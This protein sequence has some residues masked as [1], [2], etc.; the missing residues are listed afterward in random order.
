MNSTGLSRKKLLKHV[1]FFS[2]SF[3][4][5]NYVDVQQVYKK[6]KSALTFLSN[7]E[8][9]DMA[10][11]VLGPNST[12]LWIISPPDLER[13]KE[14]LEKNIT[15]KV[16]YKY[17]IS[18]VTNTE[19]IAETVTAE[20]SFDLKADSPAR[21]EILKMLNKTSS[22]G[23]RSQ[24]PFLFPKFLKVI[25]LFHSQVNRTPELTE[26]FHFY[27]LGEKFGRFKA[28]TATFSGFN[29]Q[30]RISRSLLSKFNTHLP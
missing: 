30:H 8:A 4:E 9:A 22:T 25:L 1:H 17:A 3:N 19:K 18:R 10:A 15:L 23:K 12:S 5:K 28:S 16:Q 29:Y 7:Y 20:R 14:D 24:L 21:Q 13:L 2:F 6:D 26:D 27:V 11:V